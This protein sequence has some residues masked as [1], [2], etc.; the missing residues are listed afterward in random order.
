M[1]LSSL[2]IYMAV[3]SVTPGPNN[4]M[5]M[6]LGIHHGL[7]GSMKFLTGSALTLLLKALICGG[8]NV[9]LAKWLPAASVYLKWLGAA[10]MLYLAFCIAKSGFQKDAGQEKQ[11]ENTFMAGVLLQCLNMKSWL[12]ALSMFSVYVMP[13]TTG[14]SAVAGVSLA[15]CLLILLSSVIWCLFGQSIRR[16]YEKWRLPISLLMAASLVFCAWTAIR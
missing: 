6:Y 2:L 14:F 7:R 8:L 16:L 1:K 9:L 10:Y 13:F 11:G 15:F 5:S 4:L 12:S 3:S